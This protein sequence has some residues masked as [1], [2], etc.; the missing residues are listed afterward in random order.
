MMRGAV[1]V[2]MRAA[3][4][5]WDARRGDLAKTSAR[6]GQRDGNHGV[7]AT[8][9]GVVCT[10]GGTAPPEASSTVE[11]PLE[12]ITDGF[13]TL[14]EDWTVTYLNSAG[15]KILGDAG[16][17]LVGEN[18]WEVFPEATDTIFETEYRR[19]METQEMHSFESYYEPLEV[20]LEVRAYPAEDG[21][22]VFFQD[23]TER[24]QAHE[25]LQESEAALERLHTLAADGSLSRQ[26]KIRQ[27]L[28][29]G[30]DRLGVDIGFLTRITDGTL[31]VE[32]GVGDHP[33]AEAGVT[34]PLSAAYCRHTIGATE[35]FAV[36]D[37]ADGMEN[38]PA[39]EQSG[40]ACY[41]GV[42]IEVDGDQYGTVCFADTEP[43]ATTFTDS[44]KTFVELLTD[45][46]S[47]L[48]EQRKY[49]NQR[50]SHQERLSGILNT[51]Q[52]LMQARDR[53]EVAEI[54]AN[55]AED[56]LGFDN[57]VVHLYDADAGILEPAAQRVVADVTDGEAVTHHIDEGLPGTV[58]AT[59]E[60][61]I[62]DDVGAADVDVTADAIASA[63]SY[64]MGVHGTITVGATEEAAFDETDEQVLALLATAAA[65]A[66][67]R[68][69]REREVREAREHIETVLERI[70]GLI[71]NTIE[72]LVGATTRE[73]LEADVVDV[74]AAADPYTFAWIGQPDVASE[75]LSPTAW[76]GEAA[77]PADELSFD[78]SDD[79]P[80]G[81]AYRDGTPQ[82]VQ[83]VREQVSE[84]SYAE[85]VDVDG[86]RACI[87][88]PLVYTDTTYGVVTVFA[89]ET[90]AFDEREQVVLGALGRAVANAINA[91]ERGR[92]LDADRVIEL[93]FSVD[94]SGLLFSRLSRAASCTLTSAGTDYRS[95]GSLQLYLTGEGVDGEELVRLAREDEAV[96]EAHLIV[97]HDDECLLEVVVEE[98][99]VG[100][101][102]EHG[103]VPRSITA[104]DGV[105]R[106]TVELPYEAE[107]RDLFDLVKSRYPNTELVGYH[108][109]ERP[110]ETRQEFRAALADRFTDRQE[111][112]L[113]T[114]FLGGFF[115]WPR[116]IDGNE[117]ADAMDISRPT[118]HQHL[119]AA[120]Q[121]VLEELFDP[122]T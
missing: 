24:K 56:V 117:L 38:D 29:V 35:P 40:L 39:F 13:L 111:T 107:A 122:E 71:E 48:L 100:L 66:S 104:E 87:V 21:L 37:A 9:R 57:N 49:A 46:V 64:P 67:T 101:V 89:D 61:R 25:A 6:T 119:R 68:A 18:L 84:L 99:L 22:S 14:D 86:V 121:K 11:Q 73:E 5:A 70:N 51:T 94:D 44:E 41:L 76:A 85:T 91:V 45:W 106:F 90:G 52:S 62:I 120:Q 3:T 32:E 108:E 60:S 34:V 96:T 78:L 116:G 102:T 30:R 63:M 75:T 12:R 109:H 81:T 28:T 114:A 16:E 82:V 105:A 26:E 110:V 74:L 77:V 59:G 33:I 15:R 103:A 65:A 23:V 27:I 19:A 93:E 47:Y 8:K 4:D 43:R 20:W 2:L 97:D 72:V 92:I 50:A 98:S 113:R 69:K 54:A 83:N 55:A 10:D 95:D 31:T 53:E 80:V 42:A 118:Y 17:G 36:D 88:V 1:R 115:E 7:P 112:A 58:F 79:G